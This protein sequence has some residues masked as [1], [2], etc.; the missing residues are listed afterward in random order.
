MTARGAIET[1]RLERCHDLAHVR[2][3]GKA[4]LHRGLS[5]V[6]LLV[7]PLPRVHGITGAVAE[8]FVLVS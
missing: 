1:V 3:L 4:T 7:A 2:G 8:G 6:E 5:V